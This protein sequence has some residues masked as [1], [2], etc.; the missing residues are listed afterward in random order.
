MCALASLPPTLE[1]GRLAR[2]HESGEVFGFDLLF[3]QCL[4]D[5]LQFAGII[6]GIHLLDV[7][8][9]DVFKPQRHPGVRGQAQHCSAHE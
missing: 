2:L 4:A 8:R 7:H 1:A 6:D 9:I 3:A 5:V